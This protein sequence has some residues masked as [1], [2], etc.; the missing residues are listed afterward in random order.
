MSFY[1]YYDA[2][3]A[4]KYTHALLDS[5]NLADAKVEGLF[6][7]SAP[8]GRIGG[9]MASVPPEWRESFGPALTGL[10]GIPIVSRSSNG[11]T[12]SAFDPNDLGV[13]D[14][15]PVMDLVHYGLDDGL[16]DRTKANPWWN[17]ISNIGGVVFPRGSKSVLLFGRHGAWDPETSAACY[18]TPEE[19]N[20]PVLKYK[21]PH[22][23]NGQ[24]RHQVWAYDAAEL[25]ERRRPSAKRPYAHWEL[26]PPISTEEKAL[27]GVAYDPA[28]GLVYVALLRADQVGCCGRL[29]LILVYKIH[30]G[31]DLSGLDAAAESGQ[32]PDA[33]KRRR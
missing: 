23:V 2:G 30:S 6:R 25:L 18:G 9:Y 12:V 22:A 24:Y 8:A 27:G 26:S 10:A 19:C 17:R 4:A 1:V 32:N 7:P 11:P 28:S 5:L 16:A 29:P 31:A 14:P 20:D 15:F 21:G 3:G 13:R 33:Q